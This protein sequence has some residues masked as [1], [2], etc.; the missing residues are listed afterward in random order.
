[1][2]AGSADFKAGYSYR[3]RG[4]EPPVQRGLQG[5]VQRGLVDLKNRVKNRGL[6]LALPLREYLKKATSQ[7]GHRTLEF[8]L[9][10]LDPGL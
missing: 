2:A 4:V 3:R 5:S 7:D 9:W 6:T 10:T 8:V 1:M